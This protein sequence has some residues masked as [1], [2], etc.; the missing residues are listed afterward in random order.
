MQ[1]RRKFI[2]TGGALLGSV[3]MQDIIRAVLP[4]MNGYDYR[5][6]ASAA[7]IVTI[8]MRSDQTGGD[9]WFDPIGIYIE[10]GQMVRW[11]VAENVHTTTAYHPRNDNHSLRIP[12]DAVPWSSGYL[13]NPGNHFDV[14]LTAP[15]VYDYYCMPHEEAGMVGRVIVGRPIGPGALPFDYYKGRPGT[16][17]WLP[18]PD[19]AQ[20][21]FPSV[22]RIMKEKIVRR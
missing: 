1:T 16:T 12:E 8:R 2:R 17:G 22:E 7:N 14:T 11:V 9:V 15:G 5:R 20:K 3:V 18:V 6:T 4:G 13:V 10:P 19:A 21:A